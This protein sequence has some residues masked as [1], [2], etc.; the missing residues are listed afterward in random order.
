MSQANL[1]AAVDQ[2]EAVR[3]SGPYPREYAAVSRAMD[4]LAKSGSIPAVDFISR[5]PEQEGAANLLHHIARWPYGQVGDGILMLKYL[6]AYKGVIDTSRWDDWVLS[7]PS[8]TT[9]LTRAS[10]VS[11]LLAPVTKPGTPMLELGCGTGTVMA[12][13]AGQNFKVAGV[14]IL[15]S[16]IE[17]GQRYIQGLPCWFIQ[18]NAFNTATYAD[19]VIEALGGEPEVIYSVGLF[20]YLS[21][22]LIVR[23]IQQVTNRFPVKRLILGNMSDHEDRVKMDWMGWKLTYRSS[24]DLGV[25]V[26]RAL[27]DGPWQWSTGYEFMGNHV[28]ADIR[29]TV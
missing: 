20:D 19:H 29:K 28:F 9:L 5:I 1:R 2:L 3:E 24:F 4:A 16:A 23:I 27:S 18:G 26:S 25:L 6:N 7:L 12:M 10:Y 13:L 21:D 8:S 15:R 17:E 22:D 11:D 14:E